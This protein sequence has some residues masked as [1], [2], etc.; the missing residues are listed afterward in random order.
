MV[1]TAVSR[2]AVNVGA[3]VGR[4]ST[5]VQDR[6]L[7]CE[8]GVWARRLAHNLLNARAEHGIA[9]LRLGPL[10]DQFA[11]E[12]KLALLVLL[13]ELEGVVLAVS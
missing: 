10:R 3:R 4:E 13:L 8:R 1:V 2:E 7:L 11:L 9:R 5:A 6:D 12:D